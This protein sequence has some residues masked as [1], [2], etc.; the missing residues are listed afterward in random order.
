M[1]T[2]QVTTS[3]DERFDRL[4]ARGREAVLAGTHHR[5]GPLVDGGRWGISVVLRPDPTAAAALEALAGEAAAAAGGGHWPT[6]SAATVHVTVLPLEPYREKVPDSDPK[7]VRYAT[8]LRAAAARCGPVRLRFTG[9]SLSPVGVLAAAWPVDGAADRLA[10]HLKDTIG[11]NRWSERDIWYATLLHFTGEVRH[12][13]RLVD[14]VAAHRRIDPVPTRITTVDLVAWS[15]ERDGAQP[16]P[17]T[18]A[19]A[20]LTGTVAASTSRP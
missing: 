13:R 10:G 2:H 5:D 19:S 16:L 20:P 7:V 18:L 12:P 4:T 8:G 6:G 17:V 11:R 9:V 15:S 1:G 3:Y 14:W